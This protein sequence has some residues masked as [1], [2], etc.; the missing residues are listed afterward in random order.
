[1]I[2]RIFADNR[3][4]KSVNFESGL[5]VIIADQAPGADEK[6]SRNGLGK[7]SLVEVLHFCLGSDFPNSGTLSKSDLLG[8]TFS[9][10]MTLS[11][12]RVVI[13]RNTS[14]PKYIIVDGSTTSWPIQPVY[15][16][17]LLKNVYTLDTWKDLLG[18]LMFALPMGPSRPKFGPTFRSLIGYFARLG[19][20][21]YTAPFT[22]RN[23]Q[24]AY[25]IQVL[26]AYLL[27]LS[28]EYAVDWQNLK[29]KD[30]ELRTIRKASQTGYFSDVVGSLGELEALKLR[31]DQKVQKELIQLNSFQ[32]HPQYKD[33]ENEANQITQDIHQLSNDNMSDIRLIDFY[34]KSLV[35][36]KS[37]SRPDV[38]RVYK[39][40]GIVFPEKVT[41]RLD[42]VVQFHEHLT[43][44]RETF[45]RDEIAKLKRAV[46]GR[47]DRK[48]ELSDQRAKI[49]EVL[50]TH[51][52]LEEYTHLQETLNQSKTHLEDVKRR[53][54]LLK[55][56]E[57]GRSAL[58]IEREEL[59]QN[60]RRDYEDRATYREKA[61]KLFNQCSEALYNKPGQL[62]IDITDNGYSFDIEIEREQSDGIRLM[63]IFCY[64][65]VL[66]QLWSNKQ[67]NPGFIFHDS[68]VF[69]DVD[70]R[71]IASAIKMVSKLSQDTGF[72]YICCL[73]SDKV[74]WDLLKN[75]FDLKPY[76]RLELKDKPDDACLFGF[77]F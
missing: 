29:N 39:E 75:D 17:E 28:W 22:Y 43:K 4:F 71:Q 69:A 2:H 20:D 56:F 15:D 7:S 19:R 38:E 51:K 18:R 46:L 5:N 63:E 48:K 49:L 9:C 31:L 40:V 67:T 35:E 6:D 14:K 74:P 70:E 64:D 65:L 30:D 23:N 77:R 47:D 66:A 13:S 3:K 59:L 50:K 42:E 26:N 41:K 73:N 34:E 45:L 37:A 36:E 12:N 10:D 55:K 57:S 33:L 58:R 32:V 72:Q 68:S 27:S 52:A 16:E 61:I 21:G 60:T 62:I 76:V 53:I 44:N 11:G 1:M 24:P 25:Q 54:D 8:W